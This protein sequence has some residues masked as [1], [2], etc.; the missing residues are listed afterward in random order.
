MQAPKESTSADA[1]V[2][3]LRRGND[4]C[5]AALQRRVQH[6]DNAR[7]GA[8]PLLAMAPRK[9]VQ[10]ADGGTGD[11]SGRKRAFLPGIG[12]VGTVFMYERGYGMAV[13]PAALL[14][15]A[16]ALAPAAV[17]EHV[18]KETALTAFVTKRNYDD[19]LLTLD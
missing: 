5:R 2:L 11:C 13:G 3:L 17:K 6:C 9:I 18:D 7:V 12:A 4:T 15:D 19:P 10:S 1:V 8:Q 16:L 14:V